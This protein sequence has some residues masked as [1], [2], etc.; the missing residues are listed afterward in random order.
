MRSEVLVRFGPEVEIT[1]PLDG[2]EPMPADV[3]RWWLD[4][5][6]VKHECTPFKPTGKVLIADKVLA[7]PVA[8][9]AQQFEDVA[10][11]R[12]YA[13]ATVSALGK[14]AVRIDVAALT[15]SF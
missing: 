15:V 5:Q 7:I 3:A 14:P 12:D 1:L 13:R 4:E 6:F 10:W 8:V 2:L 9:G 11:A